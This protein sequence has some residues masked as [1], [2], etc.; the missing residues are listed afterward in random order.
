MEQKK[1]YI[2]IAALLMDCERGTKLYSPIYGECR[3]NKKVFGCEDPCQSVIEVVSKY[4]AT[5]S[6]DAYGRYTDEGE[7][8]LFPSKG[9]RDWGKFFKKGQLVKTTSESGLSLLGLFD[10][11]RDS[12]RDTFAVRFVLNGEGDWKEESFVAALDWE[13]ADEERIGELYFLKLERHFGGKLD[14]KRL[15]VEERKKPACALKPFDKVLVR[16]NV[17]ERWMPAFFLKTSESDERFPYRCFQLGEAGYD[18]YSQ[19]VPYEGHEKIAFTKYDIENLP[20]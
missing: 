13:P 2:N 5:V 4:G 7:P 11:W 16:D 14:R 17:E 10:Y 19:C 12:D 20:F 9:Q 15:Q 1:D 8:L 18:D 3:L 6:L